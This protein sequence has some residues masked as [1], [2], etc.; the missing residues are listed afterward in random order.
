M[1]NVKFKQ[2]YVT[3]K[4]S[5]TTDKSIHIVRLALGVQNAFANIL[6]NIINR[7]QLSLID[8]RDR[9]VL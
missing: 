9:I 6:P 7:Y 3:W 8:P 5:Q 1:E 2:K 4:Q